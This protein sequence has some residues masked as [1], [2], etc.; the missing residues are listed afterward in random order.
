MADHGL[1]IKR[2]P[3]ASLHLDLS[4]ARTHGPENLEA[5]VGSLK[6]FGQAEPLVVQA[7]EGWPL[8]EKTKERSKGFAG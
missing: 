2:V 3:L 8:R 7:L 1:A 5:I 6:Q 4:N